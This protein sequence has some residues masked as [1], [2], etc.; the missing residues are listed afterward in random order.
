LSSRRRF[1]SLVNFHDLGG[2]S[3]FEG[4]PVKKRR[5]LRSAQPIG[6]AE[7]DIRTLSEVYDVRAVADFRTA[8]EALIRPV[9]DIPGAAYHNFDLVSDF[10]IDGQHNL[11]AMRGN[12]V[13]GV[14]R[15]MQQLYIMLTHEESALA[16]YRRFLDLLLSLREGSVLF[17]CYA[18]KDRTG[19][20]AA[21][22]LT[23]LGVSREDV[24]RDYMRS[25]RM[26][27]ETNRAIVAAARSA[28]RSPVEL[29][30]LQTEMS[31]RAQYLGA[32]FD[33][34][35][36]EFGSFLE[37]VRQRLS[38]TEEEIAGLRENYLE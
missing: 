3:G 23:L 10:A 26:R 22:A 16:G 24:F 17:H 4:R 20:A 36:R 25:N 2:L 7:E 34:A 1:Q 33:A 29:R 35:D 28:G 12:S 9:D 38:V 14:W 13:S 19:V 30:I 31:V 6:L 27:R 21:I 18:G 8:R 32:A 15:Y 5:L 37:M 11:A